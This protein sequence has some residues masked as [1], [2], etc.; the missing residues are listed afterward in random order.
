MPKP[1]WPLL[2]T[3][4]WIIWKKN[5]WTH[6]FQVDINIYLVTFWLC[7]VGGEEV[8]SNSSF[9]E[10]IGRRFVCCYYICISLFRI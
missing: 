6:I 10:N 5:E 1:Q 8:D 9:L 7:S 4:T 3:S 2:S